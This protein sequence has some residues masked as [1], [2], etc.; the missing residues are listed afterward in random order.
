[1][2]KRSG[3]LI[4]TMS[5]Q[6]AS[7]PTKVVSVDRARGG[8]QDIRSVRC[9]AAQSTNASACRT[10]ATP[11]SARPAGS[12]VP[13]LGDQGEQLGA[14]ALQPGQVTFGQVSPQPGQDRAYP[15]ASATRRQVAWASVT[16]E[17]TAPAVERAD[18]DHVAAERRALEQWLD[19]HRDT[20][21]TKCAGLTAGQ[22]KRRAVPPSNLSL[23]GLAVLDELVQD[24]VAA[25][26]VGRHAERLLS[27]LRRLAC[28]QSI[29]DSL[30][31]RP[32]VS[33]DSASGQPQFGDLGA[34]DGSAASRV[35]VPSARSW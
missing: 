26:P 20:L 6:P 7:S 1:M 31:G 8:R 24:R 3:A 16:T 35:P 17:W 15:V 5:G 30:V 19:Y 34:P 10:C 23:L 22:L 2:I 18:P 4:S 11:R 25:Q 13:D 9:R 14:A 12:P 27:H 33:W 21:L 28:P 29:D 32:L